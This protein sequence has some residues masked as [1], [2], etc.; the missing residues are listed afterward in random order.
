MNE[1]QRVG[2]LLVDNFT[3]ISL[4]SAIEPLRMANQLSGRALYEWV[5]LSESGQPVRASDGMTV[6]PDHGIHDAGHLD[7]M[8]LCGGVGVANARSRSLRAWL[9]QLAHR[10]VKLGALCT[11]SYLLADAGVLDG[12]RCTLHWEYMAAFKE[13]FPRLET[14]NA[15]YCI[16]RDRLTSSGGTVPMDM[17]LHLIEKEH[18]SALSTAICDMFLCERIRDGQEEQKVLLR[19]LVGPAQPKLAEV[20]ALMEANLEEPITLDELAHYVGLSRRQVERLFQ[21]HV[22]CSPSRYYLNL[23]LKR[24]RQ[25]LRQ[26]SLSIIDIATAC[27]FVSTPHF[28]KCYRECFGVPPRDDRLR[29]GTTASHGMAPPASE[30]SLN[31]SSARNEPTFAS[32]TL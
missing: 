4:A 21:R 16:D 15:L 3:M 26:T 5:M 23:R 30:L 12:Y 18:S 29:N 13:A 2:F 27:G 7:M 24:A 14:S 8:L 11:G 20:V 1:P 19:H 31:L 32:V 22:K 10:K 25:L 17:M 28:S 9:Q 6:T